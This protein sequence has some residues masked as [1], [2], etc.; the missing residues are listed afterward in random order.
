MLLNIL[1]G[2]RELRAPLAAGYLWLLVGWL[3]FGDAELPRHARD[4]LEEFRGVGNAVALSFAAYLSG[5]LLSDAFR[6]VWTR[7]IVLRRRVLAQYFD[8]PTRARRASIARDLRELT[9]R[10]EAAMGSVA[11]NPPSPPSVTA[12]RE[13]FLQHFGYEPHLGVIRENAVRTLIAGLSEPLTVRG[14]RTLVTLVP[15]GRHDYLSSTQPGFAAPSEWL[16]DQSSTA[17]GELDI[18]RFRLLSEERDLFN[19]VDRLRAEGQ[20]RLAVAIPLIALA[21][22]LCLTEHFAWIAAAIPVGLFAWQGLDRLDESG[23]RL[24][25][26]LRAEKVTIPALTR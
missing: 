17:A 26:A 25:D 16:A 1:P 4:F 19:E 11:N 12:R 9:S 2:L 6:P 8:E 5:A 10:E 15:S 13:A 3:A 21:I 14:I 7:L 23:E 18:A 20:F 22:T 24:V